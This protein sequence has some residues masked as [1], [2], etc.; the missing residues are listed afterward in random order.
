LWTAAVR[1][2]YGVFSVKRVP[3]YAHRISFELE[4]GPIGD[5]HVLHRCDVKLCVNPDHLF[6]GTHQDNMQ[7]MVLKRRHAYKIRHGR[8]KLTE[9][10]VEAIKEIYHEG[11]LSQKAIALLYGISHQQV[12]RI[13]NGT[14][15]RDP[16]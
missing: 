11:A 16:L 4:H 8:R 10:Q 2:G 12:S 9:D 14:R 6:L 7:D 3:T 5:S 13:V 15:W 1:S